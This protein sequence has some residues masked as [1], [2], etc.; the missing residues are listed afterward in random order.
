MED[1]NSKGKVLVVVKGGVV[2]SLY[3]SNKNIEV[4]VLDFDNLCFENQVD[5][6]KELEERCD[7][8]LTLI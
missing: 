8:L 7:G 3:V 1:N 5:E 6:E 4:E 2:Q